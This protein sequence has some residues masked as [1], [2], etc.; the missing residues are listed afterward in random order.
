MAYVYE[1]RFAPTR[2][3]L[4]AYRKKG[5]PQHSR[6]C[7]Y[8]QSYRQL[9]KERN[10]QGIWDTVVKIYKR[11]CLLCAEKDAEFCH[12]RL[13]AEFMTAEFKIP[14]IHITKKG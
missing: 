13:L 5:T 2:E 14:I 4:K 8:E 7:R 12:R 11:P 6:W 3:M 10:M 1:P 9:S